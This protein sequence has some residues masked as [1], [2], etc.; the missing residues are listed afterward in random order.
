MPNIHH[1][2]DRLRCYPTSTGANGGRCGPRHGS[3]GSRPG[4]RRGCVGWP[5]VAPIRIDQKPAGIVP[6][7]LSLSC[8]FVQT[9][10]RWCGESPVAFAT[11]DLPGQTIGKCEASFVFATGYQL[12]QMGQLTYQTG[13]SANETLASYLG[14]ATQ[15]NCCSPCS[16]QPCT[17]YRHGDG[18]F[19]HHRPDHRQ[20]MR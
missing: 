9:I 19:V 3:A 11:V 18:K 5:A 7:G 4:S 10:M 20:M 16:R 2:G 8:E 6:G 1:R 14:V 12:S 13:P 17:R 15:T